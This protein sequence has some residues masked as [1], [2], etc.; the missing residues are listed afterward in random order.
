MN[1]I[2]D[3]ALK[4]I[5]VLD[6]TR[7]L[8]GPFTTMILADLG[9]EVIKIEM[10]DVGDD[11]RNFGPYLG[12]ESA[13]FMSLNR[14]KRSMTL[15]LKKQAGKELLIDM[16]KQVDVLVENFRP[17]TMEKLGLSYE[18]LNEVNP[19][20][21]Y[22]AISGF[23]QTGPYCS[24]PAYDAIIQAMGGIMS[25]TGQENG[26]PTRVGTSVGDITAGLF[27]AIG[28]LAALHERQHSGRGQMVDVSMLDCQVAILENALA[29]YLVGGETPKPI[30]NRH[31][32]IVPFETFETSDGQIMIAVGNDELWL[33]F[34]SAIEASALAGDERYKTNK[35]RNKYYH[36]LKPVIAA[37]IKQ[38]TTSDWQAIME[39]AGVPSSAIHSVPEL[40][41]NPQV[42]AREMIVE[43]D[44]PTAG[45]YRM[46]GEPIKLSRTPGGVRSAAPLL[47]A[48]TEEVLREVFGYS[49]QAIANLKAKGIF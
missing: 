31:P 39:E 32:S 42:A 2:T 4:D 21:V 8:A 15:D 22:A 11:S 48:D 17:G 1:H 25:I 43:M 35:L 23:G 5:R 14:N 7:V 44:H 36:I 45:R 46:A 18:V 40:L 34:C 24:L 38:K 9:A 13:Y 10:P 20:L 37:R 47:G 16:A 19:R 28:I 29:R 26:T 27:A 33:K 12:G 3:L 49:P 30:G 6:L 41:Y